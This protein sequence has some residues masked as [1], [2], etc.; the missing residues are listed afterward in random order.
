MKPKEL[1]K[2][3]VDWM[4]Q[5]YLN[6]A[7]QKGDTL[8]ALA[9]RKLNDE[10]QGLAGSKFKSS[11]WTSAFRYAL[12]GRP[13]IEILELDSIEMEDHDKVSRFIHIAREK[14]RR[15]ADFG[16]SSATHA[17][18]PVINVRSRYAFTGNPTTTIPSRKS[19]ATIQTATKP[20]AKHPITRNTTPA[21]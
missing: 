1:F 12:E 14:L 10:A 5:K 9:F 15:N 2:Y 17:I 7:F 4:V 11:A 16:L 18:A 19:Q 8:Y 20:G 13:K 21:A 6:P 3:A